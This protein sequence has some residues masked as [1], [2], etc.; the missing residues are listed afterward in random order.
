MHILKL[1]SLLA[2]LMAVF[3]AMSMAKT[4][5]VGLLLP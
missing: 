2:A 3:P 4:V 5:Q 1:V